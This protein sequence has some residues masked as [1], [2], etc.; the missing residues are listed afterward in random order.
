MANCNKLFQEFHDKII[1]TDTKRE[2]LMSARDS[3]EIRI[4]N[5][6]KNDLEEKVPDFKM[7]GS[8][9]MHTALNPI[10]GEFDIDNG[11][12][13]SNL[14]DLISDWPKP[15]TVHDWIYKAVSGHT[16]E[17]P[18]NKQTCV[19]VRY[20][21]EYHVDL[22]IY[23]TNDEN[24]YLADTGEKG[25]HSS[26]PLALKKWFNNRVTNTDVQL[27]RIVRYMKAWADYE[28]R[29]RVMPKSIILTVLTANA[30]S[31]SDD[32]DY[33]LSITLN[34]IKD[35]VASSFVVLNPVDSMEN[36][37]DRL[38]DSQKDYFID[39][40]TQFAED[41]DDALDTDNI[42]DACNNWYKYFGDRFPSCTDLN[43]KIASIGIVGSITKIDKPLKEWK[44]N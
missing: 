9:V 41:S 1:L 19:R 34:K 4:K 42:E 18:Q 28:S 35:S 16:K 11:V 2:Y 22:P 14:P 24:I 20:A 15:S 8:F 13:L 38:S 7:Q 40:I 12:Y 6:F 26:D 17:K 10:N 30:Y 25:W 23:G 21:G 37:A 43:N 36:L 44:N 32:D 3:I 29:K 39:R 27:R 33:C 5:Y 31:K